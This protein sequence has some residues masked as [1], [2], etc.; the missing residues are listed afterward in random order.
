MKKLLLLLIVFAGAVVAKGGVQV[1]PFVKN[2][3]IL[4][5]ANTFTVTEIQFGPGEIIRSLQNGDMA[6]WTADVSKT[7]PNTLFIKPTM[8]DSHTNMTVITDRH[9]YYFRLNSGRA[10]QHQKPPPLYAIKFRY[11]QQS[12]YLATMNQPHLPESYHW[13][14]SYHGSTSIMP[15]HVFDDGRFTYFQLRPGQSMPAIFSVDARN[16]KESIVNF[17]RSGRYLVV[18][19]LAPQFTLRS[20]KSHVAS[21]FNHHLIQQA[22]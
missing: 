17:R 9:S 18:H 14:Y 21:I 6:A 13:D 11:P 10:D 8:A 2:Q 22:P 7:L 12:S 5:N 1:I 15:L 16:G 3:V 19:R 20:G 4:V